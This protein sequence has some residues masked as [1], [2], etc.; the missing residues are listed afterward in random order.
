MSSFSKTKKITEK[1][2]L[3][4][5]RLFF[6]SGSKKGLTYNPSVQTFLDRDWNVQSIIAFADGEKVS[7]RLEFVMVRCQIWGKIGK[8]IAVSKNKGTPKWIAYNG[9]PY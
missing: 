3:R 4:R 8:H 5:R 1:N 7:F 6:M 2:I 9:K